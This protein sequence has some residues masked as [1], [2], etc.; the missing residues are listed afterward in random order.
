MGSTDLFIMLSF[1][2]RR[3]NKGERHLFGKFTGSNK[4]I[5]AKEL[6]KGM[7]YKLEGA[8]NVPGLRSSLLQQL[9]FIRIH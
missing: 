4:R 6:L 5:D 7:S 3:Q 9:R 1:L 2:G 8:I